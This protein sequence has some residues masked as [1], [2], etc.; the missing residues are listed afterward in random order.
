VIQYRLCHL[1]IVWLA[2]SQWAW[3]VSPTANE[4]SQARQWAAA[5]F[6]RAEPFFSFT[7]DGR[8]SADMLKT[9]QCDRASRVLDDNRT[10][11]TIVYIDP[12][13]GMQ[14]RCVAI[15]YSDYP[16]VEWTLYLKNNGS[17]DTPIVSELLPLDLRFAISSKNRFL[18]HYFRCGG[19]QP[20]E[21][22]IEPDKEMRF[23]SS[24]GRPSADHFPYYNVELGDGGVILA[25]GWPGQWSSLFARDAKSGLRVC[26]G[27]ELTHFKLHPGEEVRTPLVVVQFYKGDWIRAQNVWRQWMLSHNLPRPGGK[28]IQP[29][30]EAGNTGTFGYWGMT[31]DNQRPFIARYLADGLKLDVWWMDLG[32][33]EMS[34]SFI[35][36]ALFEPAKLR[37]PKGLR[38]ISKLVHEKGL[39]LM[40]WFEPEHYF[41]SPVNWIFKNN[42]HWLLKAP[43]GHEKEPNQILPLGN[44]RLFDMGNPEA[45]QWLVNNTLR[46][47]DEQGID[48]Y[49]HDFNIEPLIFWRGADAPDRQGICENRYV[50]GFLKYYDELLRRKPNLLIDNCASGGLRNDL[51]TMRRSVPLWRS[52]WAFDPDVSQFQTLGLAFWLPYFGC[53]LNRTD[54]YTM[55]SCLCP[56]IVVDIDLRRKDADLTDMRRVLEDEWRKIVSPNYYGDYYPLIA[57]P[58]AEAEHVWAAWQFNRPESGQ[59][60]VQAFRR[61]KSVYESAR[62]K[63]RGLESKATY[64]VVD[65]DQG[66]PQEYSGKELMEKGLSVTIGRQPGAAII[67]YKKKS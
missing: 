39:K 9:W 29:M 27:Q 53:G 44:R 58:V 23:A 56:S 60:V 36:S 63:L 10:E 35:H 40:C 13:T 45:V 62:L 18:L 28:M 31:E 32:W 5:R 7:Y 24:G 47:L 65:I 37:F 25:L 50:C 57:V 15:E 43:P 21:A 1:A 61:A 19:A 55:R 14:V 17:M 30:L 49:R 34:E 66:K 20:Q 33:F 2:F 22:V 51:E 26:G 4:Q 67:P 52:D 8:S 12:V 38:P 3:A 6:E 42:P 48:Y 64:T 59:G 54:V 41:P 46:V 16:T 11:R